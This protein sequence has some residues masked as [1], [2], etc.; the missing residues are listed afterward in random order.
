MA[1]KFLV[2]WSS[3]KAK[4]T[5]RSANWQR[6]D[7]LAFCSS[8]FSS[9]ATDE[10]KQEMSTTVQ[11][12]PDVSVDQL[13]HV[14]EQLMREMA[15]KVLAAA[16]EEER[17]RRISEETQGSTQKNAVYDKLIVVQEDLVRTINLMK[18]CNIYC[19]L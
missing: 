6:S 9:T 18:V 12:L 1:C 8:K 11:A 15:I 14:Q 3:L 16:E 2:M 5:H 7:E 13:D 19:V 10:A 4:D 17:A